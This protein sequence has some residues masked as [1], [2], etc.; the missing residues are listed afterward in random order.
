MPQRSYRQICGVAQAL[1]LLGERWTLLVVRELMLGPKR[2][3]TLKDSLPGISTNLLSARLRSLVDAGIAE[4]IELPAPASVSAYALTERG[5]GLRP[6][7]E[8]LAVWGYDLI[9]AEEQVEQGWA[10]RPS[11]LA[12]TL[13]ASAGADPFSDLGASVVNFDVDGDRFTIR[14]ESGGGYVRHGAADDPDGEVRTDMP[15]FFAMTKGEAEVDD[16]AATRLLEILAAARS[17]HAEDRVG[18]EGPGAATE[19][20][21][22]SR[23][24][25]GAAS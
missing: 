10:T 11:W 14:S 17:L 6:A 8:A 21:L 13:V 23:D 19:R 16:P 2:F 24:P 25:S 3:G 22:W 9:D 12:G 15:T 18:A 20:R 1:D 5:E 4:R 7:M